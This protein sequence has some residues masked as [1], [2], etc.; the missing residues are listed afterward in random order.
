MTGRGTDI[1]QECRL[2]L[3]RIGEP[4]IDPLIELFQDKNA[5][6]REMAAELAVRRGTPGIVPL[7]GGLPAGRPAGGQGGAAPDRPA[8]R[9]RRARSSEHSAIVIALGQIGTPRGGR[10]R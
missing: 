1:F 5:E 7:Q 4:S 6:I 3:V 8:G 2:A 9:A 10:R